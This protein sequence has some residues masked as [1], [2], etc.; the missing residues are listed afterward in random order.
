MFF[1]IILVIYFVADYMYE[2][3]TLNGSEL[4]FDH[5]RLVSTRSIIAKFVVLF[6]MDYLYSDEPRINTAIEKYQRQIYDN[7]N[8]IEINF[9][10]SYPAAFDEYKQLFADINADNLC[11]KAFPEFS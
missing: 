10:K 4:I 2:Q 1:T 11:E 7:D 9:F 3:S 5:M 6:S 8:E